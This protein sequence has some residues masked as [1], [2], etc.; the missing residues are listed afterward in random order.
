MKDYDS[1]VSAALC[2]LGPLTGWNSELDL[3][4]QAGFTIVKRLSK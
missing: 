1:S 4:E 3:E 2:L